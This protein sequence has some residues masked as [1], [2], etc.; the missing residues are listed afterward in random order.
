M[1]PTP[2]PPRTK[3]AQGKRQIFRCCE[4]KE[5]EGCGG[6]AEQKGLREAS[7]DGRA[8]Q[9]GAGKLREK[10]QAGLLVAQVPLCYK[11][12]EYRPEQEGC[13]TRQDKGCVHQGARMAR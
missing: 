2:K 13:E 9:R 8:A 4:E 1:R 12:R 7:G 10:Q 5:A 3:P 11:K 6:G